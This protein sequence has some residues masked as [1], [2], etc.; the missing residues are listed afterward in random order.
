M[1]WAARAAY[2]KEPIRFVLGLSLLVRIWESR[3]NNLS[4]SLLEALS[5][6]LPQNVRI[7]AYPMNSKDL[8]QAAQSMSATHWQ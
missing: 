5:R 2:T 1:Q 3:Y 4:G 8:Q 6:L 7:Y